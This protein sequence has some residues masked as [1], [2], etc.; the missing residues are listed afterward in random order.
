MKLMFQNSSKIK[1]LVSYITSPYD[2]SMSN[3]HMIFPYHITIWYLH[4]TS[5]HDIYVWYPPMTYTY[6]IHIWFW[7][8]WVQKTKYD[9][10]TGIL[11]K[12][13]EYHKHIKNWEIENVKTWFWKL[14]TGIMY[15]KSQNVITSH[16]RFSKIFF[17]VLQV[18]LFLKNCPRRA[19]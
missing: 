18:A 12:K 17:L 2:I 13:L 8:D 14:S 7:N 9:I 19:N 1:L 3:H 4:I 6:D 10:G 16:F 15:Q 11:L 5:P